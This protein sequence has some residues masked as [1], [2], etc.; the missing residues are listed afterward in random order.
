VKPGKPTVLAAI[1][2]K[3]VIGLPGNPTS[4]LAI[5]TAVAAPIVAALVGGLKRPL[6]IAGVLAEAYEK[7]AGWTWLVPVAVDERPE[8]PEIRPLA[9]HSGSVS[10]LARADGFLTLGE[11]VSSLPAGAPVRATRFFVGGS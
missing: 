8:T 1:D 5:L 9:L 4:A 7:R 3:P 2:G 6:T 10:L 11:A